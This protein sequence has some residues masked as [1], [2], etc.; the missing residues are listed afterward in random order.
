MLKKKIQEK[1]II[2]TAWCIENEKPIEVNADWKKWTKK[3][4]AALIGAIILSKSAFGFTIKNP[5]KM[6]DIAR[7]NIVNIGESVDSDAKYDVKVDVKK[8]GGAQQVE[9]K[10][11]KDGKTA[12]FVKF[13]GTES[14]IINT[15]KAGLS[16]EGKNDEAVKET[17]KIVYEVLL[18]KL[19][20]I[21]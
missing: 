3:L 2:L 9:F 12:G 19:K 1:Y 20:K 7:E 16:D 6:A 5:Q 13:L 17:T 21:D 11:L 4:L 14:D 8:V 10:F 15:L 18:E